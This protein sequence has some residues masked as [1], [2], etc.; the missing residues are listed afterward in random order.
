M[1]L[2]TIIIPF[3]NEG[4]QVY[5][6]VR[7]LNQYANT[8]LFDIVCLN[9]ASD[10]GYDYTELSE[11]DNVRYV[12][13]EERLGVAGNRDK[14]VMFAE[15]RYILLLDGHMRIFQDVITPLMSYLEKYPRTLFCLQSRVM[16]EENGQIYI[17]WN[18]PLC[19]GAFIHLNFDK[20][21]TMFGAAWEYLQRK[22]FLQEIIDIP[23][24]LGA[25]YAIERDYYIHLHGL[26]GLVQYGIDETMLSIKVWLEGGRCCLLRELEVAHLYRKKS[27]S[28]IS[29]KAVLYNKMICAYLF[30]PEELRNTYF[31]RLKHIVNYEELN[32]IIQ[33]VLPQIQQECEYLQKIFTR[34]FDTIMKL[35]QPNHATRI[36][37]E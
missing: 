27:P 2:L 19:R 20:P 18:T 33:S 36:Y 28:G 21:A 5:K 25:A 22:D 12:C 16:K 10:D 17:N 8:R 11:F 34:D 15:T 35:N 1:K 9:D 4:R 29:G 13:N 3:C 23:C 32:R 6:T 30:M 37:P 14:G 24:V 31:S 26:N 7:N